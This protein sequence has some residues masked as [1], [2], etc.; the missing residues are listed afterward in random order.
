MYNFD[1]INEL[2]YYKDLTVKTAECIINN[3]CTIKDRAEKIYLC[4]T[5]IGISEV[6]ERN[7]KRNKV[8]S[9]NFCRQRLCPMCQRRKSLKTYSDI[10]RLVESM[11]DKTWVHMVLTVKNVLSGQLQ[12]TISLLYKSSSHLLS[13]NSSMKKAYHGA[14]RCLEITYNADTGLFHPHLHILLTGDKSLNH[15]TRKRISK[16]QLRGFWKDE[17]GID[18]EPQVHLDYTVN[19]GVV[20]E[21]AKY[22]CKPL[23]LDLPPAQRAWVLESLHEAL[24]GRRTMQSYGDIRQRLHELKINLDDDEE[25]PCPE[26]TEQMFVYDFD[27]LTYISYKNK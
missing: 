16:K 21:I 2:E 22:C 20:A 4:G 9:A 5:H 6:E 14:L 15:N 18:Y 12:S 26:F 24:H 1:L 10:C 11:P 17:L 13:K 27:R 25:L 3:S 23:E 19:E 8:S 7:E